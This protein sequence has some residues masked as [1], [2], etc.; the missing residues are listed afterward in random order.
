MWNK[1]ESWLIQIK[2]EISIVPDRYG[3]FVMCRSWVVYEYVGIFIENP[4]VG[5]E[6]RDDS[7]I[8]V[9]IVRFYIEKI[10]IALTYDNFMTMNEYDFFFK[11]EKF[12]YRL[13]FQA[14]LATNKGNLV[15][16]YP[17]HHKYDFMLYIL[18]KLYFSFYL[19]LL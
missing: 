9:L 12:I 2:R 6:P 13:Y 15:K 4:L 1:V 10:W 19:N 5:S 17:I 8:S 14:P 7:C 3:L 16:N 18:Y 11:Y